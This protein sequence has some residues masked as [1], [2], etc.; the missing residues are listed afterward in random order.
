MDR[1]FC[2]H[3]RRRRCR[4]RRRFILVLI[5]TLSFDIETVVRKRR[6]CLCS[7]A[8]NDAIINDQRN[9]IVDFNPPE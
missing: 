1:F 4:P 2:H 5:F 7:F 3:N 6:I 8:A 9:F